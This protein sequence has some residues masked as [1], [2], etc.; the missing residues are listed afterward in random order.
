MKTLSFRAPGTALAVDVLLARA[1]PQATAKQRA[2]ALRDGRVEVEAVGRAPG[3][4]RRHTVVQPDHRIE[5][6]AALRA[7]VEAGQQGPTPA[8]F[9]PIAQGDGWVAVCKPVGWPCHPPYPGAPSALAQVAQHLGLEPNTLRPA[10]RLD[11]DVGGVWLLALNTAMA[12]AMGQA[13]EQRRVHK[14]YLALSLTPPWHQGTLTRRLDGKQAHTRF[15]ILEERG[16]VA[17]IALEPLTGR[18]HQL[19]RHAAEAGWPLLADPL[20]GGRMIAGGLRLC[21]I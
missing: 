19:R 6:G 10:H 9:H 7:E 20:Y 15:Q 1:W 11:R 12:R 3:R 14:R 2:A 17:L 5:P 4:K 18:T 21:S 16:D 13:F 8:A